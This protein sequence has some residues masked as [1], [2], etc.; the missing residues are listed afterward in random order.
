M[1]ILPTIG[2]SYVATS[3][4]FTKY[5]N[6][7]P[8]ILKNR[9]N[10]KVKKS[11]PINS[12]ISHRGGAGEC[13]ENTLKAFK[14]AQNVQTQ[15]L[16][17]DVHITKDNVVVVS[18]DQDLKRVT[19][20]DLKIK[21]TNFDELPKI[22]HVIPIDFTFGKTYSSEDKSEEHISLP[23][24]EDIFEA[25]PDLC[26][27]ID[28]KTYDEIL[29]E[30]V[31]KLIIKYDRENRTIWGNFSDKTTAKCYKTNPQIGLLF[32]VERV[33]V[34][35]IYFYTGLLPYVTLKE[36]HLEIP[37]PL[38]AYKK[39]GSEMTF[40]QKFIANLSHTLLMRRTLFEHLS[41]RG[42]Q[43]YVWV[44]NDEEDFEMAFK[45][46]N[47]TGVMTDYPSLLTDYLKRNPQ[48]AK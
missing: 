19:G 44:L 22:K 27:N 37:M 5:P 12:H 1:W 47:V 34:L 3:I 43:T 9:K 11:L 26:I 31:N 8:A 46:L 32:S 29:I 15:M 39:Y 24:L 45:Q 4:L 35:L 40:L 16:E 21:E 10:W 7:L 36:T 41:Q 42:I 13:Y 30:E 17:L 20:Q 48:Y 6:L 25:F 23:K 18:H 2:A 38:L 28:I 33:L 14:H